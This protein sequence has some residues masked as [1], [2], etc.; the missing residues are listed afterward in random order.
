MSI[1]TT[2][3]SV[4]ETYPHVIA[5]GYCDMQDIL[6]GYRPIAHTER[7]EGWA[8]DVYDFGSCAIVT[9]YAPFGN[10]KPTHSECRAFADMVKRRGIK[11]SEGRYIFFSSLEY[12]AENHHT[13]FKEVI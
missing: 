11:D 12:F 13:M 4:K 7:R 1:K 10:V 8:A 3:K 9:G 2:Q 6:R 5:V